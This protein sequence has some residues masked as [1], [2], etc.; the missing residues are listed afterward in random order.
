MN[1][2]EQPQLEQHIPCSEVD[3]SLITGLW[4]T[5]KTSDG[6]EHRSRQTC[7]YDPSKTTLKT[8]TF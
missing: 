5:D 3:V 6:K 2:N 7:D 4:K 1:D 8:F